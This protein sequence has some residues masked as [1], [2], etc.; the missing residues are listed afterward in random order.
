MTDS[1][2][3]REI[4]LRAAQLMYTRD[5]SEYFQ[6]KRKAAEAVCGAGADR[7]RDLPSN[8]E[9]REHVQLLAQMLEGPARARNLTAMRIE[10]LRFMRL[11][12][13]WRPRLIGSV[14]TGHIRD[15]SDVDLHVFCDSPGL[16]LELIENEGY[17]ADDERK[18]VRKAG[19]DRVF[20]HIHV[21]A[22][23]PVELTIYRA[24][25][26]NFPFRSSITGGLIE[27]TDEAGLVKLLLESDPEFDV[28]GALLAESCAPDPYQLFELLLKPLEAVKQNRTHHPEGDALYHSLQVFELARS[29][30]PWDHEFVL[31]ALLHDV[32]KGIDSANHVEAAVEAL[33]GSISA[34]TLWLIKHHMDG[35]A[36]RSGTLGGRHRRRLAASPDIDD[37]VLLSEL[38]QAGRQ[39]GVMVHTVEEAL[40]WLRELEETQT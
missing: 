17:R 14:L 39:G 37:L 5:C 30:R 4:A 3:R 12:I 26:A 29:A 7:H 16:I 22:T 33:E 18:L 34:R 10:A 32:G 35:H 9:I 11:L 2:T 31:A 28:E 8:A 1:K 40:E 24:D 25:E 20:T 23:F 21:A 27:R 13:R 15:G 19:I 36:Y 38:D 6:A